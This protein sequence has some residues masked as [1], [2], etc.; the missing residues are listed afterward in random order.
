[1][2]SSYTTSFGI[3]KIGS[4]E[5]SGA[6]GTTTNHNL[7]ILDRI[8]SYKAV[9]ITTN[10]DTHTLTVR[11]ASPGSGTE[12]LQDGMY[13]VIKFTGAL[14]SN[15]TV[16]V[17]PNTTAAFFIIINATTDSGSSGPYSVILTQGSGANIT[18]ENGKSA[19]VYMD[20]AGSGAAVIDALSNLQLATI[21]ASGDITS[22]GT[23]NALG[24]TAASDKA[25]M[26]YTSA[27]GL[28]LTG[29]GSTNDV[30]IK[31]DADA[32]VIT[33]A[34]GATNVD[35]VGDLTASTLNAD[36]DT[37]ASDNA[38]I[39]YTSAEGIIITG[40]GSTNDITLKNDADAEVC[41]VPTGTDDLRFPD[42]AKTEWGTGGDLQIYHDASNSY[43]TDNG[44]GNLKIGSGNQ[45]DILGTA[46][47][48]ATFV[49]DG[50]VSLYHNNGVKIATTATGI[51]ITGTALATTDTDTSNTGSVTLDFETN[52][53]FILTF[54]G[55][56]TLANPTTEQLGQSGIIICIQDG[57]G[58]RTLSLGTDYETAGAAGI[59][60]STAA[61]AV[62]IIPY[63]VQSASNILLGAVQK[64]F[65]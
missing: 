38:A 58:S 28:I 2:A 60:L 13:R 11:E 18:V 61:N 35:V 46:E 12:N 31:N 52:Q 39:G 23:F 62:D 22:S 59:T 7:D 54:T 20:G 64:A 21:T 25:A 33:I 29:Q 36:G 5:Q 47:T 19:T 63:F 53:N 34:T 42:D 45:V 32:D 17:A 27:E 15:C 9:A 43:I 57:T 56:V 65:A 16:T 8:S 3:E 44:T 6:W 4:G 24:D 10:A 14:D 40:Q 48:L 41:G 37:A 30:T 50:A 26:G 49:D 51:Q 1:M 55:N